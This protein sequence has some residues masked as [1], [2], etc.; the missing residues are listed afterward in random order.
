[1]AEVTKFMDKNLLPPETKIDSVVE[2]APSVS[3]SNANKTEVPKASIPEV[4][5]AGKVAT[6][7]KSKLNKVAGNFVRS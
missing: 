4:K 6:W 3:V 5:S 7:V 1:M 2:G